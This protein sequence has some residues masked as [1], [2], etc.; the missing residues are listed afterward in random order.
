[1]YS[2][3]VYPAGM[4][5]RVLAS[6]RLAQVDG[7]QPSSTLVERTLQVGAAPQAQTRHRLARGKSKQGHDNPS[8]HHHHYH[9]DDNSHNKTISTSTNIN[10]ISNAH[11]HT[12][13]NGIISANI[14]DGHLLRIFGVIVGLAGQA[15][16]IH[17]F[18]VPQVKILCRRRAPQVFLEL[19]APQADATDVAVF[20]SARGSLPHTEPTP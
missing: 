16:E 19:E 1:M 5:R 17:A 14:T 7:Q 4:M 9:R 20:T 11:V 15:A 8:N 13:I 3:G 18:S 2:S 12:D 10:T 6:Q